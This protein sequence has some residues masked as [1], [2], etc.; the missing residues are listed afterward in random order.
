MKNYIRLTLV[1]TL[2]ISIAIVNGC[3]RGMKSPSSP[4]TEINNGEAAQE[5]DESKFEGEEKTEYEEAVT[6]VPED[7]KTE[8][9]VGMSNGI[10]PW[11]RTYDTNKLY[12]RTYGNPRERYYRTYM[13]KI[14]IRGVGTNWRWMTQTGYPGGHYYFRSYWWWR[15]GSRVTIEFWLHGYGKR[16]CS[17]KLPTTYSNR[18]TSWTYINY[19]GGGRCVAY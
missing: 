15:L 9:A 2:I 13:Y 16:S 11:S 12:I 18:R 19:L 14:R 8:D 1:V 4:S 5:V 7:K 17:V 10:Y 6:E 3:D